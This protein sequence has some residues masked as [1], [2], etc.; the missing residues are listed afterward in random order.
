MKDLN[1]VVNVLY[2][3]TGTLGG[4]SFNSLLQHLSVID[5]KKYKPIIF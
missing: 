4:G 2:I 3:E 1:R 5:R